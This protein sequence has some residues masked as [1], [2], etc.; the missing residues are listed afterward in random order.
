MIN[1][2]GLS[3]PQN[4]RD[5]LM[6]EV[7]GICP[8]PRCGEAIWDFYPINGDDRS[9]EINNLLALCQKHYH[10]AKTKAISQQ[11]LQTIRQLLGGGR[12]KDPAVKTLDSRSDYLRE[13]ATQLFNTGDHLCLTYVGPLCLHPDWYFERRDRIVELPNMD[14]PMREYL[15][16]HSHFRKTTIRIIF[17]NSSR[18]FQKVN[19]IV[20]SNERMRFIED[21]LQEIDN[22]WGSDGQRGPDVCCLDTGFFHIPVL[23]KDVAIS[24]SRSAPNMPIQKGVLYSDPQYVLWEKQSFNDIFDMSHRGQQTELDML[25]SFISSL[26]R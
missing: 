23:F 14:R 26:W 21:V 13:I 1:S 25:K 22:I 11:L 15:R 4:V 9:A 19:E 6:L 16:Q 7:G 12:R 5:Q 18:Y 17:R 3:I 8:M 10:L 2:L 20:Q 24:A